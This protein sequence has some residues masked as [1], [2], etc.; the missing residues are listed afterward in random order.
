V[1]PALKGVLISLPINAGIRHSGESF[2]ALIGKAET[3]KC[4][5][6]RRR[7]GKLKLKSV[8]IRVH[9]W[10]KIRSRGSRGSRFKTTPHPASGQP[11]LGMAFLPVRSAFI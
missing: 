7:S 5:N 10:L 8:F 2:R 1:S 11:N 9:S 6:R 4:L 3:L